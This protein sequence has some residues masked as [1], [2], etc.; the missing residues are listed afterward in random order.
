MQNGTYELWRSRG[1]AQIAD[2]SEEFYPPLLVWEPD[3]WR[4]A[5]HRVA[6]IGQETL[7]WSWTR[8]VTEYGYTWNYEEI[9]TLRR[10]IEYERGVEAL[11]DGYRQFNF[12]ALQPITYRSPFWRYFRQLKTCLGNENEVSAIFSNVIRCAANSETG[13]TLWSIPEKDRARYLQWQKGLLQAELT[14]LQPTLIVFV[15]GPHYDVYLRNEFDEITFEPLGSFDPRVVS[16][17]KSPMLGAPAYR[18]YHP[19]Y[20]NR[21]SGFA[22]LQAVVADALRH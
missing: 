19:G 13:Y 20:L 12:A 3:N 22:P 18:T 7:G 10:F 4:N 14:Q 11:I 1:K 16:K 8:D 21:S 6:Y 9:D 5:T 15:T 2:I 17:L